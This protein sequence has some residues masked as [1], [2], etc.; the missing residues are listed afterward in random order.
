[1]PDSQLQTGHAAWVGEQTVDGIA[2]GPLQAAMTRAAEFC[3][4]SSS[5]G[6]EMSLVHQLT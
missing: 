4:S 1:M 6:Q 2:A 3:M 5:G